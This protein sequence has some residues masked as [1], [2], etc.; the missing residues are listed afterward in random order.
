MA[1]SGAYRFSQQLCASIVAN[2][3]FGFWGGRHW[4][5]LTGDLIDPGVP[6]PAPQRLANNIMHP[7]R[8]R[9]IDSGRRSFGLLMAR[10]RG[11]TDQFSINCFNTSFRSSIAAL[12]SQSSVKAISN[13][14]RL[15][16]E[17]LY[18]A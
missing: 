15:E 5:S 6:L 18:F 8:H 12:Y 9:V 7:T 1:L 3:L 2:R 13:C 4:W 14:G 17:N 16:R 11:S 10:F